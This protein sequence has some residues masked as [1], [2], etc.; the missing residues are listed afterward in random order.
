MAMNT[1]PWW[2]KVS[3]ISSGDN[4]YTTDLLLQPIKLLKN[5]IFAHK[6]LRLKVAI[7]AA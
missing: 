6:L 1:C 7:I 3:V 5:I 4:T 2:S